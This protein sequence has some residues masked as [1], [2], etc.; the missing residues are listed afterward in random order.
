LV[1]L[2]PTLRIVNASAEH[3]HVLRLAGHRL[4][5]THTDGNPLEALVEVDAVPIAPAER[6]DVVVRANH[7]G[8]AFHLSVRSA[9]AARRRYS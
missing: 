4:A 5:V 1:L 6:Y 7:P 9:Q 8:C 3:T 2:K